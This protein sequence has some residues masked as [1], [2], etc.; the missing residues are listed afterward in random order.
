MSDVFGEFIDHGRGADNDSAWDLGEDLDND[1]STPGHQGAPIRSMSDPTL[2][3]QPDRTS[4]PLWDASYG[5]AGDNAGVHDLS[6][7]PNK[8]AYLIAAGGTFNGHTVSAVGIPKAAQIYYRTQYMLPSGARFA[9]LAAALPAACRALIGFRSIS[10]TDCRQVDEA[11]AATELDWSA[12]NP[13]K[14][15][16]C[17]SAGQPTR[18]IFSDSFEHGTSNWVL[19]GY[20]WMA[21]PSAAVPVTYANSG[22]ISLYS[23]LPTGASGTNHFARLIR[24]ID[25]PAS[26]STFLWYATNNPGNRGSGSVRY[27]TGSGWTGGLPVVAGNASVNPTLG[28]DA[29]RVDL[30]S[31][32]GQ[33]VQLAFQAATTPSFASDWLVDD[34]KIYQCADAPGV[35]RHLAADLSG[36][37]TSV[38]LSWDAPVFAGAG[39]AGYEVSVSPQPFPGTWPVSTAATTLH[40]DGL[41][42]GVRYAVSVQAIDS[43]GNRGPAVTIFLPSDA[44]VSCTGVSRTGPPPCVPVPQPPR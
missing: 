22:Q 44:V 4:G 2:H 36:A 23:F 10:A 12:A 21:I 20:N 29:V 15:S 19:D 25:V 11:V 39:V 17:P 16:L 26:G 33:R 35:P 24:P 27:N 30:S 1:P 32:A 13:E 43:A 3:G 34:V 28:Y 42:V 31:L 37:G 41:V 8:T 14:A 6:G 38:D 18:G 40:L 7:V 9:D 5:E